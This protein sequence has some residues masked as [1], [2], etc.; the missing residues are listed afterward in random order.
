MLARP[1][2][3]AVPDRLV[4][5]RPHLVRAPRLE[6]L[7]LAEREAHV[8]AEVLVRRADEDVDVP[9]GDVDRPVRRVVDGVGPRERAG[10][11]RELD[12]TAHVG[13]GPDRV[14]R[15]RERDDARALGELRREIVVVE[16]ELVGQARDAH[17][18]AEV[19]RELEP[20]RDV[21]VVVERRHDDLVARAQ[22]PRERPAQQEVERGHA[23]AERRLARRA[24]EEATRPSRARGRR[25]RSCGC[26]SRTARRCSRCPRAGSARSRR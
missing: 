22:R 3:E 21:R 7:P 6:Q 19:V 9:R 25:A 4:R 16:L 11:V 20:R 8:R 2:L 18:D 13:R 12:D 5:G 24:A 15:D 14:R 26:S 1:E 23:L 10:R 17:D